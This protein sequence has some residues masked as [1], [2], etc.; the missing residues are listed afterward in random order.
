MIIALLNTHGERLYRLLLRLTLREDVADDLLQDLVVKL[1]Q[2]SG[3]TSAAQPYAYARATATNLA[4]SWMRRRRPER[5][6]EYF[7]YQA[8]EMPPWSKMVR[9]EEIQQMLDAMDTLSERDRVILVMRYFD[10]AGYDDICRVIGCT[11]HQARALRHKAVGRLRAAMIQAKPDGR[12]SP[13]EMI[14]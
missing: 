10:E 7:D 11:V 12:E 13:G 6:L 14:L 8:H 1:S 4:F 2:A 5:S 9:T 3:F